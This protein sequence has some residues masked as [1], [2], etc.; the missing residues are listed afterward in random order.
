MLYEGKLSKEN[1]KNEILIQKTYPLKFRIGVFTFTAPVEV[2]T[3]WAEPEPK[4]VQPLTK[5]G[6]YGWGVGGTATIK[7]EAIE[8]WGLDPALENCIGN[9]K[10]AFGGWLPVCIT[11]Y[12]RYRRRFL[13][14]DFASVFNDLK[15]LGYSPD[16]YDIIDIKWG[17]NNPDGHDLHS[18]KQEL[19]DRF[20]A[21]TI[22]RMWKEGKTI[23]TFNPFGRIGE[24]IALYPETIKGAGNSFCVYQ[25]LRYNYTGFT[26]PFSI[27]HYG[28]SGGVNW[29]SWEYYLV[30]PMEMTFVLALTSDS[31]KAIITT[32]TEEAKQ[33]GAKTGEPDDD[34]NNKKDKKEGNEQTSDAGSYKTGLNRTQSQYENII[35]PFDSVYF[36]TDTYNQFVE[37]GGGIVAESGIFPNGEALYIEEIR[38]S[39]SGSSMTVV[40]VAKFDATPKLKVGERIYGYIINQAGDY[41]PSFAGYVY[42]MQ[43]RLTDRGQEIIYECRD[44]KSYLSQFITP[45]YFKYRP[46]SYGGKGSIKTIKEIIDELL[47]KAGITNFENDLPEI[48]CPPVE[49][50]AEPL[51]NVLDWACNIAG[52]YVYFVD[53]NGILRI[54]QTTSGNFIKEI[55]IPSEGDYLKD[56]PEYKVL[57]FEPITDNSLSRSRIVILGDYEMGEVER[58]F[59]L[60]CLGEKSMNGSFD[61]SAIYYETRGFATIHPYAV[62]VPQRGRVLMTKLLSNPN[63]SP[64]VYMWLGFTR[65]VR[66]QKAGETEEDTKKATENLPKRVSSYHRLNIPLIKTDPGETWLI[67]DKAPLPVVVGAKQ[68]LDVHYA[69]RS[70]EPISVY[71]DTGY[72]GGVEVIR[73]PEFKKITSKVG[74]VDDTPLMYAYLEKLKDYFKPNYGGSLELDG[75]DIDL[76]LL[77]KVSITNTALPDEE[78]KNLYITEIRYN[79]PQKTTTINLTNKV[80][81]SG[82][83]FF[84]PVLYRDRR[85]NEIL[86]KT[87]LLEGQYLYQTR[88]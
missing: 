3:R 6:F 71:L 36:T 41:Q 14:I 33:A 74:S 80:F 58:T 12:V 56:H 51:S 20:S 37:A 48:T 88:P 86:V 83:P 64:T 22:Q 49:W 60:T 43:R 29:K 61:M 8:I 5:I 18:W 59:T 79:I 62:I 68:D 67:A 7:I 23:Y 40:Q 85:N 21:K 65:I 50:I 84:D 54:K 9:I 17:E 11:H 31:S 46:P 32:N 69:W 28:T 1:S 82:V 19:G 4:P 73:R 24:P 39:L 53:K 52:N 25:K 57:R 77:G 44:L 66:T 27:G 38:L 35:V 70:V 75:L 81:L 42:S 55:P 10:N 13:E 26:P 87:G 30:L 15:S 34:S 76:Y 45:T 16:D 47:I 78:C 63:S 2:A 72:S